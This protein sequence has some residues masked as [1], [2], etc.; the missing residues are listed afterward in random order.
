[1]VVN[2]DDRRFKEEMRCLSNR[3]NSEEM[4]Q[5]IKDFV[6]K[7]VKDFSPKV[8]LDCNC[9]EGVMVQ[10][11]RKLGVQAYGVSGSKELIKNLHKDVADY[12]FEESLENGL[13]KKL[14]KKYDMVICI[15][16]SEFL[17][18]VHISDYI[19]KLTKLSSCVLFGVIS[20]KEEKDYKN[21]PYITS[22]FSVN[23]MF[24]KL[25]YVLDIDGNDIYLFTKLEKDK[26]YDLVCKYE[27]RL[28][29]A[30]YQIKEF[31]IEKAKTD[32]KLLVY[33]N[34]LVVFKKLRVK[35]FDVS[36]SIR[37][38]QIQN[39]V[40]KNYEKQFNEIRNSFFWR[41]TY[42]LRLFMTILRK[43]CKVFRNLLFVFLKSVQP[44]NFKKNL[45][46]F[47]KFGVKG[48]FNMLLTQK[49]KVYDHI[50]SFRLYFKKVMPKKK[51]IEFQKKILFKNKITFSVIVPL[52]N[53]PRKFLEDMIDS[54]IEQSYANWQLCL[55]DGSE[56]EQYNY[57]K[58]ICEEYVKK[59]DRIL[60]KKIKN[61]LGISENTNEA[62][63]MATGDYVVLLDHD[64]ILSPIALFENAKAINE[65]GADFLYSDE[66]TF[67]K[68]D[69]ERVINIHCKPDFSPDTLTTGNYICHLSV[70]SK[71]LQEE[72][73][74][75]NKEYDGSQDYDFILRLTEKAKKIYHIPKLLYYW[76][77]SESSVALDP[78]AKPY[79]MIVGKKVLS[80]HIKRMGRKGEVTE[81]AHITFYRIKYEINKNSKISII[82]PNKDHTMDLD[83]CVRSILG[84]STYQNFEI[85]II[86]NG[87]NFETLDFYKV[88]KRRDSRIKII[89]YKHEFN[90]SAINNYGVKFATG[91]Y[92][93][94]LNND[95]E[96]IS[97]N[98]IEEMLMYAQR[99][100]VGVVGAKLYYKDDTI[101]H[102]GVY[103]KIGGIAGHGHKFLPRSHFGYA[104][105]AV[106]VQNVSAVTGA[107]MMVKKTIFF[108]VNG[109]EE[110]LRISFND[111]DFC[112]RIIMLG[113][114]NVFTPYAE[115]YH[116]ESKS[117][118]YADTPKKY[119]ELSF[120]VEY[121][122]KRWAQILEKG[123]P[124]YNPNLTL[125]D[126]R[127]GMKLED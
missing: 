65:S 72:V 111:V 86:E 54:V 42:P 118:G 38:Y 31:E 119:A 76:R 125:E 78:Y 127:F 10:E 60:Y 67:E 53:T 22:L 62:L 27:K 70:F 43:V 41:S 98:W 24:R 48:C 56:G 36:N 92:L 11:F 71:K 82:I 108:K 16:D 106:N 107:C 77:A 123:D 1:M 35:Y 105:R 34:N 49:K 58:D 13:S 21:L 101:Q 8:I 74:F 110:E 17:R 32:K 102:A 15:Q 94:F 66:M 100:D 87:S 30:E 55:A 6:S 5:S 112:L 4:K 83:I 19:E 73:G 63:K 99:D 37:D 97:P 61:N 122:Q 124:Y 64:D 109:F 81:G 20:K 44:K 69:I 103:L 26:L 68:N 113:Y 95:T 116:Y 33:A 7:I 45:I 23:E 104:G 85:L 115:L 57:V 9:I 84:K 80:E 29:K 47:L 51:E 96:V 79:C 25:D 121:M 114:L 91:E 50:L 59:D 18:Y 120:E 12:C 126:E 39:K 3:F 117:R 52:Y 28:S 89:Y 40:L 88:L 46:F 2:F 93:L 90:Y 14:Q 75:F